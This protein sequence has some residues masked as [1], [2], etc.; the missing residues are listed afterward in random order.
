ML[1]YPNAANQFRC[2]RLISF[3][4][5]LLK[6]KAGYRMLALVGGALKDREVT[7]SSRGT[8]QGMVL[9]LNF[10]LVSSL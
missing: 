6:M 4:S 8:E 5:L 10:M 2:I 9:V 1:L 3:E 7:E